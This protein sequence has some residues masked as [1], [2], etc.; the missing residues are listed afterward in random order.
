M[1]TDTYKK[2]L[3]SSAFLGSY[4]SSPTGLMGGENAV[5]WL[6]A[7]KEQGGLG[8]RPSATNMLMVPSCRV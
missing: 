4:L 6:N 3:K 2:F 5:Q 8:L 1:K 7:Q